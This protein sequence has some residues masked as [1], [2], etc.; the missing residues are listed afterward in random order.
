MRDCTLLKIIINYERH[1][2][3]FKRFIFRYNDNIFRD[4]L[5]NFNQL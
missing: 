4:I 1:T 2:L 3:M 5:I